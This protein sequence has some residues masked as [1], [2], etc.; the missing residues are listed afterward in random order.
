MPASHLIAED[1]W[2]VEVAL[3]DV[4]GLDEALVRSFGD[5]SLEPRHEP[6][7]LVDAAEV[8]ERPLHLVKRRT[9]PPIREL[10]R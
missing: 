7:S 1:S 6:K 5:H 10:A 4:D 8:D 3:I 9:R 2:S